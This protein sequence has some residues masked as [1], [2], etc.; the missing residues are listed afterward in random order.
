MDEELDAN[1]QLW[2]AW[3]ALHENS[4]FY[5]L[6]GFKDGKSS[7]RPIERAEL[8]GVAGRRWRV[9]L[10]PPTRVPAALFAAGARTWRRNGS[11]A[12]M[13]PGLLRPRRS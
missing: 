2:D 6:A 11:Y 9:A 4:D 13:P 5:D 7:L 1:Q 12:W 10:Q 8:T 3:T